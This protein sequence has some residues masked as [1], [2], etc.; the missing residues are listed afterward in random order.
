M[1]DTGSILPYGS[2]TGDNT[3]PLRR[4]Q[5]SHARR[6]EDGNQVTLLKFIVCETVEATA[7]TVKP[8][9]HRPRGYYYRKIPCTY[10][11]VCSLLVNLSK[12]YAVDSSGTGGAK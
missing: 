7:V 12:E 11:A 4:L 1:L 5:G 2:E 3:R 6:R 8:R 9:S 10:L